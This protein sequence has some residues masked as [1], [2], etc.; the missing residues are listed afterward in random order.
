MLNEDQVLNAFNNLTVEDSQQLKDINIRIGQNTLPWGKQAGGEVDDSGVI[1]MPYMVQNQLVEDFL[2]FMYDKGLVL[3]FDWSGWNKGREWYKST[4][5]NKYEN[6]DS[7]TILKLLTT[8]IR[9]D[10][11]SDG[12][13]VQAFE[14][15][16]FP[17]LIDKLA[18]HKLTMQK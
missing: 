11:F 2:R 18:K 12:A 16:T 9:N 6:L 3:D 8:I 10:R 1:Q 15:G 7:L 14:Q 4:D 17:K 5:E 13:L